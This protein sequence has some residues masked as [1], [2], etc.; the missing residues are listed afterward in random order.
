MGGSRAAPGWSVPRRRGARRAPRQAPHAGRQ[1]GRGWQ[2]APVSSSRHR[3][4]MAPGAMRSMPAISLARAAM[5]ALEVHCSD[6]QSEAERGGAGRGG[7][8]HAEQ[9]AAARPVHRQARGAASS[10][11]R[12]FCASP[13]LLPAPAPSLSVPGAACRVAAAGH[14]RCNTHTQAHLGLGLAGVQPDGVHGRQERKVEGAALAGAVAVALC[15]RGRRRSGAR[16]RSPLRRAV[17]GGTRALR[18]STGGGGPHAAAGAGDPAYPR[19]WGSWRQ[20]GSWPHPLPRCP[21]HERT[22]GRGQ[23]GGAGRGDIARCP[24]CACRGEE[25][26]ATARRG[27]CSTAPRRPGSTQPRASPRTLLFTT[28]KAGRHLMHLLAANGLGLEVVSSHAWQF[29][30]IA[31]QGWPYVSGRHC[32]EHRRGSGGQ[33]RRG[34]SA[35]GRGRPTGA[36]M[37]A[38]TSGGPH[39]AEHGGGRVARPDGRLAVVAVVALAVRAQALD[40][41]HN[42]GAGD[43][44]LR[45]ARSERAAAAVSGAAAAG[46]PGWRDPRATCQLHPDLAALLCRAAG[47]PEGPPAS[48]EG[49]PLP[50]PRPGPPPPSSWLLAWQ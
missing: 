23:R 32:T 44:G 37:A 47:G 5:S 8:A 29:A 13:A 41:A 17:Q 20:R 7:W 14:S 27:P 40:A 49:A 35:A 6:G 19:S 9:S 30:S 15:G 3:S 45:R 38:A 26:A 21:R 50:Q 48:G 46:G 33:Q 22:A 36:A 28:P 1:G 16:A 42:L 39:L 18:G 25:A 10:D 43:G 24:A 4:W 12:G 11:M 34:R 31:L 2:A